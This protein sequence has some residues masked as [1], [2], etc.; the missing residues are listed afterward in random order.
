M[1][2]RARHDALASRRSSGS[3]AEHRQVVGLGS[4]AG[5]NDLVRRRVDERGYLGARAIHQPSRGLPRLV[6]ARRVA[7][8][9]A[10]SFVHR[11]AHLGVE[12]R[13][14]VVVGVDHGGGS[15]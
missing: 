14:G 8:R 9:R 5:E 12:R 13:G 2:D 4:T 3:D 6:H 1:L 10:Q 11:C 15:D 7:K